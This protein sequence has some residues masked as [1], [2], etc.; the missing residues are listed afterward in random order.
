MLFFTLSRYLV[1]Q[2]FPFC[3]RRQFFEISLSASLWKTSD[4]PFEYVFIKLWS[5]FLFFLLAQLLCKR[6]FRPPSS[7]PL[8]SSSRP[9][10]PAPRPPYFESMCFSFFFRF[11]FLKGCSKAVSK[12]TTNCKQ[13]QVS[14]Q[15]ACEFF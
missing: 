5:S 11:L 12:L 8:P 1:L 14:K 6:L 3:V 15:K 13:K 4:K 2:F 7:P 9:P 10:S